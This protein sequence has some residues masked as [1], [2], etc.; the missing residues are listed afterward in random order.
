MLKA[1]SG[2][3]ND[4][5]KANRL[6]Q[7]EQARKWLR[8]ADDKYI[9]AWKHFKEAELKYDERMAEKHISLMR[10]EAKYGA[11]YADKVSRLN[12]EVEFWRSAREKRAKRV[13]TLEIQLDEQLQAGIW[14]NRRLDAD[15]QEECTQETEQ[16]A[17]TEGE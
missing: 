8:N 4:T 13:R 7:I 15:E 2:P 11:K 10:E 5:A 9:E 16:T 17:K 14:N 3:I 6:A 1:R 12:K